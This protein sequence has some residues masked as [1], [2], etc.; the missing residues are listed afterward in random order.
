MTVSRPTKFEDLPDLVAVGIREFYEGYDA[1]VPH[2]ILWRWTRISI[3]K[4]VEE[5]WSDPELKEED[6]S[7]EAYHL[8]YKRNFGPW[9]PKWTKSDPDSIYSII[10]T[11]P[12]G[13][14]YDPEKGTIEDGWHRFHWYVDHWGPNKLIPVA[15]A[16]GRTR[17]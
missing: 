6:A 15:W 10:L 5:V 2:D 13:G 3:R 4:L 8:F 14:P 12:P 17:R 1:E 16:V 9:P 7:F 11:G